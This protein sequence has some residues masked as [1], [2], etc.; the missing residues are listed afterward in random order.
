M[1]GDIMKTKKENDESFAGSLHGF[2]IDAGN[3]AG[4]RNRKRT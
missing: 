2:D 3:R 4:R 1:R